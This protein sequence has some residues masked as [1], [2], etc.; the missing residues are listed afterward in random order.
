MAKIYHYIMLIWLFFS[1]L[2]LRDSAEEGYGVQS[3]SGGGGLLFLRAVVGCVK[4]SSRLWEWKSGSQSPLAGADLLRWSSVPFPIPALPKLGEYTCHGQC[5]LKISL[6]SLSSLTSSF[7][8]DIF[9]TE[10]HVWHSN[11]SKS[12]SM[13]PASHSPVG[14]ITAFLV[15]TL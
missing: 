12:C 13:W 11:V 15:T 5:A 2:R 14:F 8:L 4:P 9:L 10:G 3:E 1:F 7:D 6:T